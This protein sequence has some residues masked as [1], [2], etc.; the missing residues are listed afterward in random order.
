M[1]TLTS[2]RAGGYEHWRKHHARDQ[3]M[4]V[5]IVIGAP[6]IVAFQGPQK[7]PLDSL[8][9][10]RSPEDWRV[11]RLTWCVGGRWI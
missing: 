5:A 2:L 7:L 8:T 6:P 9:K 10:S 3:A 1:M 4:P 11:V